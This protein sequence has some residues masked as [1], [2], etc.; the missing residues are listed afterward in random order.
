[1]GHQQANAAWLAGQGAAVM[2]R[3]AEL[4][5]ERLVAEATALLD[6]GHRARIGQAALGLATPDAARRLA[7]E[8]LAMGEGRPLPSLRGA[9]GWSSLRASASATPPPTAAS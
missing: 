6:D 1:A 5:G 9:A 8:L 4:D 2:V 3:D 7:E